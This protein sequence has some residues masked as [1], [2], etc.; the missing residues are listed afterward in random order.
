M[1]EDEDDDEDDEDFKP[2]DSDGSELAEEYDSNV[3]TTSSE[4]NSDEDGNENNDIKNEGNMHT[5]STVK[6]TKTHSDK[7]LQNTEKSKLSPPNKK[8]KTKVVKNSAAPSRPPSAYIL[9]FNENRLKILKDLGGTGSVTDVA[10]AA[11]GIWRNMSDEEKKIYQSMA[12]EKKQKYMEELSVYQAKV[13][14]GEIKPLEISKKKSK[15]VDSIKSPHKSV[16][17]SSFKSDEYVASSESSCDSD[18]SDKHQNLSSR[19]GSL[20]ELDVSD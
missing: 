19:S 18:G 9:W 3:S 15:T 1:V 8:K 14:T 13:A 4:D 5:T 20:T 16:P 10:K 6:R 2:P 12:E 17:K 11:G 7:R